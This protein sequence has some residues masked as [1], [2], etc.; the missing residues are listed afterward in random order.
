MGTAAKKKTP[1]RK[2][3]PERKLTRG[4]MIDLYEARQYLGLD[5][6]KETGLRMPVE[7]YFKDPAVAASNEA[8]GFDNEFTTPW[9]PGLRDGPTSA[10]FAVVDY[11]ATNNMLTPPAIWDRNEELLS[12]ARRKTVLDDNDEEALPVPPAQRLG[13]RSEHAR[14]LRERHWARPQ[15]HLGVRGQPAD[16]RAACRIR[17][18]CLLRSGQQV[19]AVL[20]V[21]RREGHGL[22]LP[23]DRHRQSRVR[24]R[25]ARRPAAATIYES[26]GAQTAAFHEFLGDLTAIL[27]AFRNNAFRKVVLEGKQRQPRPLRSCWPASPSEFGE[28]T[29]ER[30]I[31]AQRPESTSTMKKLAGNLEPHALSEVLTGAMFDI[32]KGV[33]AKHHEERGEALEGRPQQE[34]ERRASAGR[35]RSSHADARHPAARS[36]A[37]LRGDIP[38]LRPRRA[39]LPSRSPIR[40]T[41]R[42]IAQLMLDC[43]IKRGI[44]AE[45]DRKRAARA[46][47]GVQAPGARRLPPRR[48][49]RRL[50]RRRLSLSRRQPRQAL[51]PLNADIVITEIVR[52]N[53]LHAGRVAA[54]RADHRAVS[55]GARS[56]CSKASDSAA[57]PANG[58]R[59]SA[60][61]PWCS[62]RTAT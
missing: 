13:D 53:K 4:T 15:D 38:G 19:A 55:S 44:L 57:S 31:S 12:G 45:A 62:T 20:L 22:H 16:R 61:P 34:A 54:A 10:R 50:A 25:R 59:C 29:D 36:A 17:R 5:T 26:V 51:I 37:A 24:P 32:L 6:L 39:A 48:F 14:F 46:G 27:M 60:A 52:A 21:R 56:C 8:A 35:H 23:F 41:P 58:R 30:P 18:E 33:F 47:A 11:D 40:P 7:V 9:E 2:K 1:T 49:D 3:K 28:A 42:A 43:F